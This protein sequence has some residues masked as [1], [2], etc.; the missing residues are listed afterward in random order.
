MQV[1][2]SPCAGQ[3]QF[4][5]G[6]LIWDDAGYF[7]RSRGTRVYYRQITRILGGPID[8]GATDEMVCKSIVQLALYDECEIGNLSTAKRTLHAD[9]L[10]RI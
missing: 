7:A 1:L 4:R 6:C 5:S 8:L 2:Q 10:S 3:V 9:V